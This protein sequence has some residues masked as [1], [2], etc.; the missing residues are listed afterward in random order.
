MPR[1]AQI[2]PDFRR[3]IW[4]PVV[5]LLGMVIVG[6]IIDGQLH[7]NNTFTIIFTLFWGLPAIALY[8]RKGILQVER[9]AGERQKKL[10]GSTGQPLD[11]KSAN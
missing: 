6:A 1:Q 10:Q 8:F 11:V 4:I 9:R 2:D 3:F 7:T 5:M